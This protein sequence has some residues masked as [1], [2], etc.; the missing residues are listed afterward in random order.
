MKGTEV[1]LTTGSGNLYLPDGWLYIGKLK[2][3]PG[4]AGQIRHAT[5]QTLNPIPTAVTTGATGPAVNRYELADATV[6]LSG[7]PSYRDIDFGIP[8]GLPANITEVKRI[9]IASNMPP[10]AEIA[11][12]Q[13][14]PGAIRRNPGPQRVHPD[15]VGASRPRD[16]TWRGRRAWPGCRS[17]TTQI[18]V[19]PPNGPG[20]VITS[21]PTDRRRRTRRARPDP[22][23][24]TY[25]IT[26]G[27]PGDPPVAWI[28]ATGANPGDWITWDGTKWIVIRSRPDHESSLVRPH[29]RR[30]TWTPTTGTLWQSKPI[31]ASS[32]SPL[33]RVVTLPQNPSARRRLAGHRPD[34]VR[35]R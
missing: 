4:P 15:D 29:R 10:R 30:S 2:G 28:T 20:N 35:I 1:G 13:V 11:Q 31:T 12:V 7:H 21:F 26:P 27:H 24:D 19:Q 8:A 9:E 3:I 17:I 18:F 14:P 16:D 25:L 6:V 34:E 33:V 5:A 23:G 32:S 22:K